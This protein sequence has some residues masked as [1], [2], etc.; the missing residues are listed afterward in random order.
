M[1][2]DNSIPS[3]GII[4]YNI[5]AEYVKRNMIRRY[6]FIGKFK[7]RSR[8]NYEYWNRNCKIFKYV[9]KLD[10]R[11]CFKLHEAM[12]FFKPW[13]KSVKKLTDPFERS[14][15]GKNLDSL[16]YVHKYPLH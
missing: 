13:I 10:P 5:D 2:L 9:V 16:T 12:Q 7:S 4:R 3:K 15:K 14:P 8:N 1:D 6:K 11:I